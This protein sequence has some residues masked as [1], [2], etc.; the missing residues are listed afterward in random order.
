VER[1][2]RRDLRLCGSTVAYNVADRAEEACHVELDALKALR[3]ARSRIRSSH[4]TRPI[5]VIRSDG[6]LSCVISA[7]VCRALVVIGIQLQLRPY[8]HDHGG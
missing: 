6:P 8:P 4:L 2:A 3:D 7:N 5:S 1:L